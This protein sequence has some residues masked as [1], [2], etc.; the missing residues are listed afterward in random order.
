MSYNSQTTLPDVVTAIPREVLLHRQV[1]L[2]KVHVPS[3]ALSV[4]TGFGDASL[5][6]N[7]KLSKFEYWAG[8]GKQLAHKSDSE[9]TIVAED[10]RNIAAKSF[11]EEK[12]VRPNDDILF[13]KVED[14]CG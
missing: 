9:K 14:L 6:A 7:N 3:S 11:I 13:G 8:E 12:I 10:S 5:G 1:Y 4:E 2:G